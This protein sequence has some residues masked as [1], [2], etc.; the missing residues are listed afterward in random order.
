MLTIAD[1]I[2]VLSLCLTSFGLGHAIGSNSSKTSL[3]YYSN[4]FQLPFLTEVRQSQTCGRLILTLASHT[5]ND[6]N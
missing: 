6:K 5:G 2:A 4:I 1:L 3:L